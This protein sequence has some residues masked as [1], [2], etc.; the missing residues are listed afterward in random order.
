MTALQHAFVHRMY[1]NGTIDSVCQRCYDT[2]AIS[3]RHV[4]LEVAE[5]AHRCE[6]TR[7]RAFGMTH[8]PPFRET[9]KPQEELNKT[10]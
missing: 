2:V 1:D 8:K 3:T 5:H 4:E 7:L 10:A 9:W 6:R